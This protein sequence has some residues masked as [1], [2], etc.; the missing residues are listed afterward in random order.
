M[1]KLTISETF[2]RKVVKYLRYGAARCESFNDDEEEAEANEMADTL[3][4]RLDN[5]EK[6]LR[7]KGDR[8]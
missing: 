3:E 6:R 4:R 7:S 1:A 8:E 5:L 2:A